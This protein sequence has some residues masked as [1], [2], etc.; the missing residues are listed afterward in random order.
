[1]KKLLLTTLSFA[2][3]IMMISAQAQVLVDTDLELTGGGGGQWGSTSTNFGTVMCDAGTCGTCG[4]PCVP[5]SGTYYAWFGGTTSAEIGTLSQT[6][7]VGTAGVGQ[8][9]FYLKI[10][11]GGG[12]TDSISAELDGTNIWHKIG[13]DTA[14]FEN[15]YALVSVN[16]GNL[17]AGSHTLNFRGVSQNAVTYNV[18]LD[19]ITLTVG[20]SASITN[21]DFENGITTYVNYDQHILNIAFNLP[22]VT[23]LNMIVT[24]MTGRTVAFRELFNIQDDYITFNTY[25]WSAGIYNVTFTKTNAAITKKIFVK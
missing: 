1:M 3:A 15:N 8:L 23:D 9:D 6:F 10:P 12:A 5:R 20:G 13:T 7:N 22:E 16:T 2:S 21:Y 24:D 11:L 18:L 25:G 19:D 4:G 14:G 17:T